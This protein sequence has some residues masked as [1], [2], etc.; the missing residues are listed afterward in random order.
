VKRYG[1]RI[2][3]VA[4]TTGTADFTLAGVVVGY[5][6]FSA[7]AGIQAG[8]T[9][10]YLAIN[11]LDWEVGLGTY[12]P[13]TIVRTTVHTSSTGGAKINFTAAPV[14]LNTLS[15]EEMAALGVAPV[16]SVNSKTGAV[17]LNS[18]DVGADPAGSAAS[19]EAAAKAASDPLGAATA[20]EAAAKA[21][22]QPLDGDLTALAALTGTGTIRRTGTNTYTLDPPVTIPVTSVNTK[23]GAVTLNAAEVGADATGAAAAA[24]AAA[25]A[26][27]Q[28]R[29]G[30]LTTIAAL[31]GTGTLRRTG[32][33]AWV[34]DAPPAALTGVIRFEIDGGGAALT[35]GLKKAIV[36][37][38]YNGTITGWTLLADISGSVVLDVWKAPYASYPPVIA[39]TITGS[40]KPTLSGVIKNTSTTLTGWGTT[41]T[42]GD[43]FLVNVD[44]ATTV[45]HA[46]LEINYTRT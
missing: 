26:A 38:P 40:A 27:S 10:T 30:D 39:G 17:V 14:V 29:D 33:D 20:A 19:A 15:A 46:L 1:D 8:D 5:R 16:T 11:G 18:S 3:Q 44:S 6:P 12:T 25:I 13:G 35:T 4:S 21:A 23:T 41:I 22:S 7:I 28:P 42:A 31:S 24:Q 37:A 43:I 32:T 2:S 34:L 45:T 36:R 9:V